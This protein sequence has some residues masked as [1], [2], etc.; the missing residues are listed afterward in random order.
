[1]EVFG[2]MLVEVKKILTRIRLRIGDMQKTRMSD[3]E[4]TAALNDA[5]TML[6]IALGVNY[7]TIPRKTVTLGNGA[8]LPED[9]YSL[10]SL[11]RGLVAGEQI[12]S[13]DGGEVK[14]VYNCIPEEAG[15]DFSIPAMLLLDVT[16]IAA[17]IAAG[18]VSGAAEIAS[19]SAQRISQKREY[20]AIPDREPFR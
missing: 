1:M 20:A 3:Y 16:E 4:L 8:A 14:L 6:W 15:D 19:A 17:A 10:V 12:Y 18:N 7:S 5:R 11:D 9:Y 13:D 2:G